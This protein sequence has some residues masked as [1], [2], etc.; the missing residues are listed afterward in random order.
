MNA[1]FI[2]LKRVL[3]ILLRCRRWAGGQVWTV[4]KQRHLQERWGITTPRRSCPAIKPDKESRCSIISRG[5]T[6][7]GAVP[8]VALSLESQHC[9]SRYL[10][11]A[12][13]TDPSRTDVRK[14]V[15]W[16]RKVS[17][18]GTDSKS[19]CF[20]AALLFLPVLLL[21]V[22]GCLLAVLLLLSGQGLQVALWV[23]RVGEDRP[24]TQKQIPCS[25]S[26]NPEVSTDPT[27]EQ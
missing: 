24:V 14:A 1:T 16:S 13:V 22:Q 9:V 25:L 26:L 3:G 7:T 2:S 4:R 17:V 18:S 23:L 11:A 10:T 12:E 19:I 5:K 21:L 20:Q 15:L 8:L 6:V 27:L